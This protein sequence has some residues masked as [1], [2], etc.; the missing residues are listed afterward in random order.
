VD[1]IDLGNAT[2]SFPAGVIV[3]PGGNIAYVAT[4]FDIVGVDVQAGSPTYRQIVMGVRVGTAL[5][6]QAAFRPDG[7]ELWW[8]TDGAERNPTS[9]LVRLNTDPNSPAYH[10]F[11]YQV[12]PLNES[13]DAV[14]MNP[15][16]PRA[17][18]TGNVD[19]VVLVYNTTSGNQTGS[20]SGGSFQVPQGV[21]T[22]LSHNAI[23]G[24]ERQRLYAVTGTPLGLF[25]YDT[26][27][28]TFLNQTQL[29]D[30]TSFSAFVALAPNDTQAYVT[31]PVESVLRVLDVETDAPALRKTVPLEAGAIP[32]FLAVQPGAAKI[33]EGL[34]DKVV[35][36][37]AAGVL[38]GRQARVLEG[39]L[40]HAAHDARRGCSARVRRQLDHFQNHVERFGRHGL[41]AALAAE[42]TDAAEYLQSLFS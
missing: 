21:P 3:A 40:R 19:D 36:S 17:Y 32:G 31:D 29:G 9:S 18:I 39:D 22:G 41:D 34:K 4:G 11:T 5:K 20:I 23:T 10:T 14:A 25:V 8:P 28:D 30:A 42:L 12:L 2:T 6:Q 1:D 24:V 38:D 15:T 33:L 13:A 26:G 16:A 35:A 37:E 27:S 7:L